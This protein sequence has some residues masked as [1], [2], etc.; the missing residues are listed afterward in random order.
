V[1]TSSAPAQVVMAA[2]AED[3]RTVVVDGRVVVRDRQHVLGDAG[4]LLAA[5]IAPLWEGT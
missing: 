2:G 5:A 4:A 1:R 3:V